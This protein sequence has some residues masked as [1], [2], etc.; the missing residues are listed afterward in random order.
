MSDRLGV[1]PIV[2][3]IGC[4]AL[5]AVIYWPG[6]R[7]GF[8]FDDIP[9]LRDLNAHGGVKD[10]ESLKS[11]VLNGWSGPTGRPLSLLSFLIDDNSWP[12]SAPLFKHTNLAIHLICGLV[13]LWATLLTLRFYGVEESTGQWLAVFSASCWLLHPYLVSTTLYVV[14]R[15]AQLAALFVFAGIT[16][17]LHGRLMLAIRPRAAYGWMGGSLVL[18]TLL[19]VLSKENG[20]LLPMLVGVIEYCAPDQARK[21]RL[22]PWFT[23]VF[24]GLPTLVVLGYLASAIDFSVNPWPTRGFNQVER[25][26]SESRIIWDY[27]GNLYLPCIEGQGLY[28]DDFVISRSLIN[29]LSTLPALLGLMGLMML[30]I[31]QRH[32]WRLFSLAVLFF[33]V[34]HLTESTV[35]GLEL[36]FEHRNY[37]PAAFLFLPV[38]SGI[39]ALSQY[40]RLTIPLLAAALL[41]LLLAFFTQERAK[42]WSNSDRLELYWATEANASPRAQNAVIGFYMRRGLVSQAERRIEEAKILLPDSSLLAMQS[43][44]LKVWI[45]KAEDVDF[46][47]AE[48]LMARQPFD[49]QAVASLRQL[50]DKVIEPNQPKSY[51]L[52]ALELIDGLNINASYNRLPLFVRLVPY[53]RGQIYLIEKVPN[54]ALVQFTKSMS[55]YA[56]TDAALQMVALTANAGYPREALILLDQA[57]AIYRQ[58]KDPSLKHSRSY[59]DPEFIRLRKILSDEIKP[60]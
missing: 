35:I 54:E 30:A 34:G 59:Y 24:I 10:W 49:A 36:Y 32:R 1:V 43:L 26:L 39:H 47:E 41:L 16:G 28:R 25:L 33:F 27:L 4:L 56:D 51:R 55:L 46:K 3:F 58:Q 31:T 22:N 12:S 42:L 21:I 17:Y 48:E 52:N 6:L 57:E 18:G 45:N 23:A 2:V 50:V 8:I 14:Q 38:A 60:R 7:G 37:L 15:M 9:N 40:A 29:P 19:A 11:F 5:T 44:L 53:L 13:L 20:V